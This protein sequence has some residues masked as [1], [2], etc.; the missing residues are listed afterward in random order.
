MNDKVISKEFLP[1]YFLFGFLVLSR[2]RLGGV[3]KRNEWVKVAQSCLT[4]CD[5]MDYTVPGILQARI[6]EWVAFPFSRGSSQPRDWTWVSCFAGGFF[7]SWA[8]REAQEEGKW[9]WSCFWLFATPQTVVYQAS[10]SKGFSRQEYRSGLPF[11]SPVDLPYPGIEPAP[12]ALRADALPSDLPGKEVLNRQ[13]LYPLSHQGK[14]WKVKLLSCVRLFVT[15]WTV[16]YQ[17]PPSMGFSRQEYWSGLPF[18]SPGDLP[19]PGFAPGSPALQAAALTR[20]GGFKSYLT[21]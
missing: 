14:K 16:A 19:D 2:W 6:L 15:P 12:P 18:P 20:E 17:A 10:P 9:K 7:T 1:L 5:P 8:T 11:P 13:M 4:L 3:T 21:N